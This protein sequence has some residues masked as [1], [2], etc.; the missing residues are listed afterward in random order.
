[1]IREAL[2]D[3]GLRPADIDYV[4]AHGTGTPL[5]DPIE[6]DALKDVLLA[7]RPADR[8][9]GVGSV[10]TNIGHLEAAAGVAGGIKAALTLQN[11]ERPPHLHLERVN[12]EIALEGTPL[13]IPQEPTPWPRE[14]AARRAGVSSFGFGGTN[15]HVV[16]EQAPVPA[17]STEA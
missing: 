15:A 16:L 2:A 7:D 17:P 6:M 14:T 13:F 5:G 11:G 9:C 3:A 8:P 4:E 10:K 12:P 1:V